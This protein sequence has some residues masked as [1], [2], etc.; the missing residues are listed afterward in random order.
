MKAFS[1]TELGLKYVQY[2]FNASNGKGHGIH[3]PFVFDFIKNVLNDKFEYPEYKK[4][5]QLRSSLL[6]NQHLLT[7]EDLGAGSRIHSSTQRSISSI[8]RHAAKPAR[9][10]KLLFRIAKYYKTKKVLEAG[11]SLGIS[12][13]YMALANPGSQIITL[14]GASEVSHMAS[15]NFKKSG[16]D[17]IK[18]LEGHFD[19][20][21]PIGLEELGEADLIFI[22]G[23]HRQQPT[24]N[25][26]NQSLKYVHND[27][28]MVFDDIHWSR[29]MED[30]WKYICMHPAVK[31]TIDLFFVG[32]VF[33][34][35]ESREKQHFTIRF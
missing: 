4:V 10:S 18:L 33:F 21:L 32:I 24:E 11:T 31:I 13:S 15:D 23:N 7:I 28:I 25:Y 6:S 2:W 5:E 14:E 22:D 8:A 30:A 20:T 27:T 3:S 17:N 9:Y 34:R 1:K 26:F 29:E 12:T 35:K 19:N 16:I